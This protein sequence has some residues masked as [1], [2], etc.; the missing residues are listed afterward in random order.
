MDSK[1]LEI[2]LTDGAIRNG[3]IRVPADDTFF[4]ASSK[5]RDTDENLTRFSLILPDGKQ[6]STFV[7]SEYNRLQ[8]RFNSLFKDLTAGDKAVIT[9]ADEG[10]YRLSLIKSS[11]RMQPLHQDEPNTLKQKGGQ[12]PLLNQILYGPPGTGKTY[13]TTEL[14]VSIAEPEWYQTTYEELAGDELRQAVKAKYDQLVT[15]QRVMFTTFHQSF[16]YE[17]F[18]EGIR[19]ETDEQS[20][21]IRYEVTDG[22]FKR[23]CNDA[24]VKVQAASSEPVSLKGKRIWKMSLGNTLG[25]EEYIYDECIKQGYL[26]L[27][28][29]ED[30]KFGD[31]HNREA[32]KAKLEETY[33][34]T[35][36]SNNYTLTSVHTFK[37]LMKQGDLVV[38]SDGNSKFRAIAE[39]T[40]DYEFLETDERVGYQQLRRVKWLRQYD[41]SLSIEHL[42]LKSLSQMTLYELRPTTIDHTKLEQLLAP[43]DGQNSEHKPHVLIIDEINRGNIS[44]IFGELIT[45]LEPDKRMGR[46]DA[47]SVILP[48]SK[49][50]FSVP[51]NLYVIGTMNTADKSLAQL[52]LALRRRFSF[53]EMLPKPELLKGVTAFG[54]DLAQMLTKINQRIEVLLDAEHLI[55]HSYFMPLVYIKDESERQLALAALIKNKLVPLLQEYFFDDH[56]R[57]GWV[58]NDPRKQPEDRFIITDEALRD[59]LPTLQQLFSADIADQLMDRRYRLNETAFSRAEAYQGIVA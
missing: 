37:N 44:R 54:V 13:T 18:I 17:D 50:E 15:K 59:R 8:K 5:G 2:T 55:G 47:R 28:Y 19:A 57:I 48:Y 31:C 29:G 6:V 34:S 11:S 33:Q 52:D 20:G 35:V 24:R 42:F 12:M 32:V 21:G 26:L 9:E 36:A 10:Q 43:A 7:L 22:V 41:P 49:K 1:A 16:S 39:V 14:A 53:V 51:D 23:L 30:I 38:V 58:L 45:L 4:P 46:A 40:G 56:Q 3:Y 25:G 27:G